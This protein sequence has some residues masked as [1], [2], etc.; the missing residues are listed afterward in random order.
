[1][2]RVEGLPATPVVLQK[3]TAQNLRS[4]SKKKNLHFI[5]DVCRPE[6]ESFWIEVL[7]CR[8]DSIK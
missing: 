2:H 7:S 1:M 8:S 5:C 6:F 4:K 3:I